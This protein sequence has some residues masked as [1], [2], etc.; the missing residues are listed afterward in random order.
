MAKGGTTMENENQP[1]E[2]QA[3]SE[4]QPEPQKKK[5]TAVMVSDKPL[6]QVRDI[7]KELNLT[8]ISEATR[9]AIAVAHQ[10]ICG[11]E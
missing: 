7:M 2:P 3:I 1:T 4:P 8:K 11:T 5:G 9:L 6:E 10:K